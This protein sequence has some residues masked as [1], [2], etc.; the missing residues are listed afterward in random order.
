MRHD[1]GKSAENFEVF[2]NQTG[3]QIRLHSFIFLRNTEFFGIH[4]PGSRLHISMNTKF[5]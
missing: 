5:Y 2:A 3:R 1:E 4:H